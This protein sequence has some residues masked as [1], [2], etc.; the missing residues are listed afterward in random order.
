MPKRARWFKVQPNPL[1]TVGKDTDSSTET[2]FDSCSVYIRAKASRTMPTYRT[3]VRPVFSCLSLL[4]L[5]GFTRPADPITVYLIGDSTL[6]IK[7]VKAYPETGWGMPFSH[8]FDTTVT[9][10]N[11]AMNG[12]STRSFIEENRWQ[13]VLTTLHDGDYVLIQFGHNDEVETKKTYT[14]EAEF[15]A[16][17]IRFIRESRDKKA[18]PILITPV[19]RRQFDAGG[20]VKETHE[21]YS[22]LVR[23]VANEYKIPLI[24]LD[25]DSQ[26]LLQQFG[27]E[28]SRLLFLQ[29]APGEHPNYPAGKEDN[30]H[31]SEL[32]ARKMAQ[33][34]LA[35]IRDQ[36]LP[37][38]D[39][40]V[41]PQ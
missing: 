33:L 36:H 19:A 25:K 9:V 4:I 27:V 21:V 11:R 26:A 1:K 12:R 37:L 29:L 40:I 16:N 5:L 10:D 2:V 18:N 39:R 30:T 34:V 7:Q 8:F 15:R 28:N 23:A 20:Q 17:L 24:D 13:S 35:A 41:K 6:A 3:H 31:F 22:G 14:P 32:G 38:A